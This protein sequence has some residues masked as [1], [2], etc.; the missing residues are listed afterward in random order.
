MV[1]KPHINIKRNNYVKSVEIFS[2]QRRQKTGKT[3]E[4]LYRL[5]NSQVQITE[6]RQISNCVVK[7]RVPR[8]LTNGQEYVLVNPEYRYSSDGQLTVVADSLR[9]LPSG[10]PT[11]KRP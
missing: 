2:P 9:P 11:T 3:G 6:N 5:P 1:I 10:T 8:D 4:T 7:V